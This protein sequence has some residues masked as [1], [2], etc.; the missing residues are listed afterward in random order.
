YAEFCMDQKI[1]TFLDL[2]TKSF[3]SFGG[4]TS[5]VVPDNLKSGVQKAHRYDPESNPTYC[6]YA[7]H[8]GFAVLPARPYS[9]KD[10]ASVESHIGVIQRGFFSRVREKVFGSLFE[11][12]Q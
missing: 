3:E 12:N 6:E 5:Y 4:V 2:H 10:K 8:M 9:P 7:N 11:L 1:D